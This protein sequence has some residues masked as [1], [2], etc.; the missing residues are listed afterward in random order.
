MKGPSLYEKTAYVRWIRDQGIPI[1]EGFGVEDVRDLAVAPWSRIGGNAAFVQLRGMQGITAMYIAEIPP[2]GALKPERH[3]YEKVVCILQGNG[4]TEVL[5]DRGRKRT[6]EWGPWSL[7]AP[8]L[9]SSHRMLN[10]GREPVRFLAVTNAPLIFDIY[11]NV[12]F[13]FNCPYAFSDRYLGEEDYFTVGKKRYPYG[14]INIWETNFIADVKSAALEAL[15][16]KG[17]GL[18]LSQFEM[19]GNAL[20]GHLGEWP[21]GRYHKAHY[22]GPGAIIV[23]LQSEGYV[24][25][26]SKELGIR[27]YRSGHGDKVVELRWRE[28]SVYCPPANWFHQHFNTGKEPARHLAVRYGSRLYPLGFKVAQQ[29]ADDDV[30]ISVE[31]G[32]NLIEYALEDPEIRARYEAALRRNGV[33]SQMPAVA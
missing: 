6:F 26:W 11:R 31:E 14:L 23:G 1:H 19:S 33:T 13:I 25:L 20:I 4:A 5:D 29:R 15:E 8:P 3:L 30:F 27:P 32:G 16:A 12:D 22:H 18:R 28:G 21:V 17:S 2:G 10:G 7:F 24:L 9:N